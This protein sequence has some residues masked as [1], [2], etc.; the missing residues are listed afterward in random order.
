L[1][2]AL[3]KGEKRGLFCSPSPQFL[4]EMEK[5]Q[6][7][8][9]TLQIP[10]DLPQTVA[11]RPHICFQLL[12]EYFMNDTP[13]ESLFEDSV[14][15]MGFSH[16]IFEMGVSSWCGSSSG[17]VDARGDDN[18]NSTKKRKRCDD[19]K[20]DD[21]KA[22]SEIDDKKAG[23][24]QRATEKRA[25]LITWL[26][27]RWET[28]NAIEKGILKR[29]NTAHNPIEL[30]CTQVQKSYIHAALM[31]QQEVALLAESNEVLAANS[32]STAGFQAG[33]PTAAPCLPEQKQKQ[34]SALWPAAQWASTVGRCDTLAAAS[35]PRLEFWRQ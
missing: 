29:K 17:S 15:E 23:K 3:G 24:I 14:D 28:L 26:Q 25:R 32:I 9:G 34:G 27:N 22:N 16:G 20:V 18:S 2:V 5:G 8:V 35:T 31:Q 12:D 13:V 30:H 10:G 7:P 21:K 19:S 33:A 6:A 11:G 1:R 4:V